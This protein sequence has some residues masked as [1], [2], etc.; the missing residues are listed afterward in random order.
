MYIKKMRERHREIARLLTAGVRQKDIAEELG[1]TQSRLSI[2][3]K[4]PVFQDFLAEIS[5]GRTA[6]AMDF[7]AKIHHIAEKG[8]RKIERVLD[9][10]KDDRL[11]VDIGFK[12]LSLDGYVPVQKHAILSASLSPEEVRALK[13]EVSK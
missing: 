6:A 12:A 8:L 5:A 3:I 1:L 7:N 4:S 9:G 13:E 10:T 11:A 2:I